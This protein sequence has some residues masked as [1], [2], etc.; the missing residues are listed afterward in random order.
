MLCGQIDGERLIPF[1]SAMRM[2][3]S[4]DNETGN[5]KNRKAP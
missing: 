1:L 2:L 3:G 4:K 5:E